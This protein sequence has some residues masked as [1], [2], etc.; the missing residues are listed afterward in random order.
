MTKRSKNQPPQVS[1]KNTKQEILGAY[2]V[3]LEQAADEREP[4]ET[5]KQEQTILESAA[6]E[7]VEK[8]TH[9]L[10]QLRLSASQTISSLTERLTNEAE[11]LAVLQKAIT[12]A[13]KELEETQKIK[14]RAGMLQNM[15]AIQQKEEERFREVMESQQNEWAQEQKVYGENLKKERTRE[16]DEY[17]YQKNLR[18]K[19]EKDAWEEEKYQWEKELKNKKE[20]QAKIDAELEDLRKK[21]ALFPVELDKAVKAAIAQTIASERKEAQVQQNF[22]KQEQDAKNQIAALR[23]S[24][25]E[26]MVKA[27]ASDIAELKRKLEQA[28][29]QVKEIAVTFIEGAKKKESE[30]QSYPQTP[31]A[32]NK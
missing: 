6:K 12:I 21:A 19:R 10:S 20:T 5:V 28:T 25:L 15:V 3:L 24:T 23:I 7:T 2:Q 31:V 30:P 32:V 11:R 13:Q 16:E 4:D 29:L 18:M 9:D 17:A 1:E 27:Q 14:I 8:I 22:A 26:N